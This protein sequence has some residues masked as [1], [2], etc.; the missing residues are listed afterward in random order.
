[1][2]CGINQNLKKSTLLNV[3]RYA[4][5]SMFER[6]LLN[7]AYKLYGNDWAKIK[8]C[9]LPLKKEDAIQGRW[10]RF[11]APKIMPNWKYFEEMIKVN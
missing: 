5:W 7:Y 3:N 11:Q 6:I 1:M 9:Y 10:R 8:E 4:P 2:T